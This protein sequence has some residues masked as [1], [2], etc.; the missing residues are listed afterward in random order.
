MANALGM[1][2]GKV[3]RTTEAVKG[4]RQERD[5]KNKLM[6]WK[7]SDRALADAR[8]NK[9]TTLKQDVATGQ[10]GAMQALTLFDAGEAKAISDVLASA[11]KNKY[12]QMARTNDSMGRIMAIIRSS[13]DPVKK[14][15]EARQYL[16]AQSPKLVKNMPEMSDPEQ[17]LSF[18]EF[19]V[20]RATQMDQFLKNPHAVQFGGEDI[21]YK[22][23]HEVERTESAASIKAKAAAKGKGAGFPKTADDNQAYRAT[24]QALTGMD[25]TNPEQSSLYS[26][27]FSQERRTEILGMAARASELMREKKLNPNSAAAAALKEFD[28]KSQEA[29]G[30]KN[31]P[32]VFNPSTG[33]FD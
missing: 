1:N 6:S 16:A 3:Y 26:S 23:G 17:I 5:I 12:D 2:L 22:G 18:A 31:A 11:D 8:R 7:T 14:Y 33:K 21:L 29:G 15:A 24:V 28:E 4:S 25:L 27:K 19:G 13:K 10:E 32:R 20:A 9:L 30:S